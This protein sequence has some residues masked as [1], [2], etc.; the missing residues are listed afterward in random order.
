MLGADILDFS[1]DLVNRKEAT[2]L[3]GA[4]TTFYKRLN[5][6]YGERIL[7][8]LRVG[9]DKNASINEA[10][11][12]LISTSG[13]VAGNNGFNGEYSFP[14]DLLKPSRFEVSYDGITWLKC[15][16]YDNAL[17]TGSEYNDDQLESFSQ[18]EPRVDFA[19][20]SYKIRPPKNTAGDITEGIYIEYEKR[21]ADFTASTAPSEIESNLQNVLAYDLAQLEI[22][23][24]A[25]KYSQQQLV[26]F[27]NKKQEVERRFLEFYKK[28]LG[29]SKK[30]TYKYLRYN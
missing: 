5:M 18:S 8:I 10:T 30:M 24:H 9:V 21:Q 15:E 28:R 13:L 29:N 1:Y 20:N 27:N 4:T 3:D 14:S 12:D 23:M 19:R 16:V 2:F 17:N 25:D 22:I 7:D 26:L 11:T 6:L